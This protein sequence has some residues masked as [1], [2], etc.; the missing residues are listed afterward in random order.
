LRPAGLWNGHGTQG[1]HG[2]AQPT[3][4][5]H[6]SGAHV[7]GNISQILG[8]DGRERV[9]RWT[10]MRRGGLQ[11]DTLAGNTAPGAAPVRGEGQSAHR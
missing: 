10:L 6:V 3:H 4:N 11:G 2:R 5:G 1:A 9:H 8:Q 7:D